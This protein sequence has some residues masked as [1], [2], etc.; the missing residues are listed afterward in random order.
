MYHVR[1][2]KPKKE[3]FCDKCAAALVQRDDDKLEVIQKR[4]KVYHDQTSPLIRYYGDQQKLNQLDAALDLD[5]VAGE[6]RRVL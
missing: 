4:L 5:V 6:L 3:G 2:A 1:S